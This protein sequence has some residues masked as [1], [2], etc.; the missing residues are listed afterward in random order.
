MQIFCQQE[1]K[2]LIRLT[3]R[4]FL[5]EDLD[6]IVV[7]AHTLNW[8]RVNLN[9]TLKKTT[10]LYPVFS[11]QSFINMFMERFS[12]HG[13]NS[14]STIGLQQWS[15]ITCC[16]FSVFLLSFTWSCGSF[17]V[18]MINKFI[19]FVKVNLNMC[20]YGSF[21][22][23]VCIMNKVM[24]GERIHTCS[25]PCC[26][27]TQLIHC[28]DYN[29][30]FIVPATATLKLDKIWIKLH[31]FL[32]NSINQGLVK[33][34]LKHFVIGTWFIHSFAIQTNVLSNSNEIS[35]FYGE[36]F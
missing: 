34:Y 11:L 8:S 32:L 12:F 22:I 23:S 35:R 16:V 15:C 10:Q 20:G 3:K 36:V 31:S 27:V 9:N 4:W 17:T 28:F 18:Y 30:F 19:K 21:L 5:S 2:L 14:I 33:N 25:S 7:L 29:V 6:E 26:F 1:S 24:A 13:V